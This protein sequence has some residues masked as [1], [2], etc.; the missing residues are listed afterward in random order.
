ME[1]T[2]RYGSPSIIEIDGE[3]S[4]QLAPTTRQHRRF[5][6]MLERLTEDQWRA[7]SRCAEWTVKDVV[8]HLAGVNEYWTLSITKG[9]EGEPTRYLAGFDPVTVPAAMVDATDE[10]APDVV[11]QR[12]RASSDRLLEVIGSLRDDQW[13]M[14]AEAPPGW[15]PIRLVVSHGLWDAWTHER[16]IAHP[17]E[18]ATVVEDDEVA[19]CLRYVCAITGAFTI[20]LGRP[21][22]GPL[23]LVATDPEVQA[24]VVVDDRSHVRHPSD[25]F[26]GGALT[27]DAVELLDA[28]TFRSPAPAAAPLVWREMMGG[29]AAVFNTVVA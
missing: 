12:F 20:L 9:L 2:P 29:L 3:P 27:G 21:C 28:L 4:D 5:L 6:G 13:L 22:D 16:D 17:L 18:L 15:L 10:D 1:L 26:V 24:E 19:S 25:D 7:Q 8:A 11:L 14:P 23:R